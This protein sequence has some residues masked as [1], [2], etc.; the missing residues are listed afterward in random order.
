M[1]GQ[2]HTRARAG[3]AVAATMGWGF[4]LAVS[5]TWV[6][7]M[8][9]PAL[10]LRDFGWW[11]LAVFLVPNAI[12]AALMGTVLRDAKAAERLRNTH[13]RAIRL[14][15][16][17]TIAFHLTFVGL[18]VRVLPAEPMGGIG[19]ALA[20]LALVAGAAGLLMRVPTA[21]WPLVAAITTAI[22]AAVAAWL[23]ARGGPI[24]VP[25]PAWGKTA[26]LWLAPILCFGFLLCPALDPTFHRMVQA[27]PSRHAFAVFGVVFAGMLGLTLLIWLRRPAAL[28]AVALVHLGV[29]TIFTCA[30]H[31]RA[32]RGHARAV[33]RAD[34]G[35]AALGLVAAAAAGLLA[36]DGSGEGVYL[37]ILAAYGLLF[38]LYVWVFVLPPRPVRLDG[39]SIALAAAAAAILAPAF[40]AAFVH[41]R[42][43]WL[44]VPVA[45]L[46]G[47]KV[48][49][50]RRD[51]AVPADAAAGAGDAARP[52]PGP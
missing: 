49:R 47:W 12:G 10:L 30:V 34:H 40:E 29:Q 17:V 44:I 32:L 14:F 3:H 24:V 41:G 28:P 27:S 26:A 33:G 36:T 15:S 39:R 42:T 11:S 48:A 5:W 9:L 35:L 2:P 23:L 50:L 21:R 37:R 51:A 18:V 7:G 45:G 19:A 16:V 8:V 25:E 20:V 22:S 1:D 43:A 46:L 38:P 13:D 52:V 31:A 4:Y 6:I